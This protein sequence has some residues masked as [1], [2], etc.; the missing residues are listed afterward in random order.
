MSEVFR[1]SLYILFGTFI[2]SVS[3]V[4]LKKSAEKHYDYFWQE[5][6]NPLVIFA[7][8]IFFLATLCSVIAYRGIPLSLGPILETTSYLYITYF[9]VKIFHEKMNA[10]KAA[11]L[12]LIIAGI[13]IYSLGG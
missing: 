10:K 6:L 2:S 8:A 11:A 12:I 13:V 4:L 5:Y 3:Q 7:Y 9:G 1:Y